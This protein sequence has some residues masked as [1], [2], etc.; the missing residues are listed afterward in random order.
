MNIKEK[1]VRLRAK[2]T[3]DLTEALMRAPTVDDYLRENRAELTGRDGEELKMMMAAVDAHSR[4]ERDLEPTLRRYGVAD[5][6][7]S[8]RLAQLLKDAD[9]L[10]RVRIW[11]LDVRH[12]RREAS[13]ARED[14]AEYLFEV[15]QR[16][17]GEST[18]PPFPPELL[19]KLAAQKAARDRARG[20][21]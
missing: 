2:S 12:L 9:G 16:E 15:Y 17:A 19:E 6:A 7:R 14:F 10:D 8:L 11:D 1:G 5:W 4:P 3:S 13:R 20:R 18:T 21:D